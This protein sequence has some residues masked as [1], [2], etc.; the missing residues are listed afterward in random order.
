MRADGRLATTQ[1]PRALGSALTHPSITTDF[2]ESLIEIISVPHSS[3]DGLMGEL[4]TLHR[5]VYRCLGAERL[6]SAS[7]PCALGE[8]VDI[9]IAEYGRSN[10]ARMKTAYRRGLFHRYG[11]RMQMV[12]GIHYNFS[13][14]TAFWEAYRE[15]ARSPLVL[16]D[17]INARYFGLLRNFQ[18]WRWLPIYLFGASPAVCASFVQG[19][20]HHLQ[21]LSA[22]SFGLEHATSLRMG[23]LGYQSVAQQRL[24]I[25]P[26]SLAEYVGALRDAIMTPYPP[27]Q[28][29][30]ARADGDHQQLS[31]GLLQIDNEYYN[32]VRP[33]CPT[34]P[35]ETPCHALCDRGVRYIEVRCLDV[36]PFTALGMEPDVGRFLEALLCHCLLADSPP[37]SPAEA[38]H[39]AANQTRVV[40]AGRRPGLTLVDAGRERPMAEWGGALLTQVAEVAEWLDAADGGRHYR[41]ACARQREKLDAPERTP[42]AK[43]LAALADS[44]AEFGEWALAMSQRHAEAF[45][46][47]AAPAPKMARQAE[48][49]LVEQAALERR[50]TMSFDAYRDAFYRQYDDC[51]A[52]LLAGRRCACG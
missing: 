25:S 29:I 17:F 1:H 32:T 18:R 39:D 46:D 11:P 10:Q 7:M 36:D 47:G 44:Q 24:F 26:N 4:E 14:P 40:D 28:R 42:S 22:Q 45:A 30:G 38:E 34:R 27:Y 20:K 9:P 49:S 13:L 48:R 8:D 43:I 50:E 3:M 6:W 33:K 35:G 5:H 52:E 37:T 41:E 21:R 19:R 16:R 31:D 15:I 23:T 51:C 2:S 12:S